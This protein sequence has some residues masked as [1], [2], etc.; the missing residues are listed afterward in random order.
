MPID[1]DLLQ[2]R[3]AIDQ[4]VVQPL[5]ACDLLVHFSLGNA[6]C[7]THADDL[8]CGQRSGAH[9]ALMAAAMDLSFDPDTRRAPD[10]ER[11]NT[12]RPIG[13]VRGDAHGIDGQ[14]AQVDVELPVACAAPTWKT[15]P[16][17]RHIA[18]IAWT[19][20]TPP[21]SC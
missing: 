20:C 6:I 9:A 18:P 8:V 3:Q 2:V 13:L 15:V 4:L 10:I 21:N 12:L 1:K 17:A 5:D 11:T 19:S 16:F 7:L 14:V